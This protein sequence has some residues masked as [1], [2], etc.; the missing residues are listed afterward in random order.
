MKTTN[1][2]TIYELVAPHV[3]PDG[4]KLEGVVV[5]MYGGL[6]YNVPYVA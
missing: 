5:S 6:S 4:V 3:V 2:Q 1:Y